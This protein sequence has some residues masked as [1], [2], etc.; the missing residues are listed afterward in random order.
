MSTNNSVN[1]VQETLWYHRPHDRLVRVARRLCRLSERKLLDVGCATGYLRRLLPADFEYFGCDVT[2][3][4]SVE[5]PADH[6]A[7]VDFNRS[8]DLSFFAGQKIEVLH[9]GGVLEYLDRPEDLLT[10][11][12]EL[13]DRGRPM[14]LSIVN[15]Q[16]PKMRRKENHHPG[17]VYRPTLEELKRSLLAAGWKTERVS[18]L[19][20][21]SQF[22]QMWKSA[23][24]K[25]LG[26][27]HAWTRNAAHQFLIEAR[28]A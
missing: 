24:A 10:S 13:V 12:R 4:A 23:A 19:L 7:Q 17:W 25:V 3:H 2:N 9:V 28:A 14:I 22:S 26:P 11:A 1:W 27:D 20:R 16:S 21:G 6:F 8:A 15:F 5:L 18:S